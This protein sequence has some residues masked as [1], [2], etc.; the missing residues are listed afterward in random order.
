[1][2]ASVFAAL[3][4]ASGGAT[5]E[6]MCRKVSGKFTLQSVTGPACLSSVQV[7]ATGEYTGDITGRSLFI[8]TS[9]TPTV[10]TPATGVILLTGDNRIVS[11]RGTLLT[12]DA[13][14]LKTTGAGDFGEVDVIVGGT[15][16]FVGASGQLRAQGTFTAA[17]GGEGR[18]S[19]E[20][21]R[22]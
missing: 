22:P 17:A 1:M 10:D 11:S 5:A 3:V 19:G 15:E 9:L 4:L 14:V 12:K 2:A 6:S 18:Y 20:I 21:C 16:A 7:C 8:G 13:I